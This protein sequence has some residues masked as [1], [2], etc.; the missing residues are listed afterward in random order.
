M[1]QIIG[2][3]SKV[4]GAVRILVVWVTLLALFAA[5]GGV[6]LT[7]QPAEA[8][9]FSGASEFKL[10]AS[11]GAAGDFFG[12]SADD[13]FGQPLAISGETA[14][15]GAWADDVGAGVPQ[16]SAYVFVKAGTTWSQQ[17]KLIAS[18]AEGYERFGWA[19]AIDGDTAVVGCMADYVGNNPEQGS[20][21]VFTRSGTTWSQQAQL[22]ASDG[23]EKDLFGWSVAIHGD[24]A[25]I[26]AS[27]DDVGGEWEVGSAYVFTRTG[28]T[29]NQQ[30]KLTATDGVAG[31]YFGESVAIDV[32]TV[33][34]GAVNGHVGVAGP[35]SA[36]VFTR[37]GTTWNQQ[38]KLIAPDGVSWDNFGE[39]VAI[40]GDTVVVGAVFDHIGAT[41]DQGSAYVFTRSGTSWSQQ[42][43]LT[44]SDGAAGDYFGIS[45]GISEDIAVIGNPNHDVESVSNQGSTYVFARSGTTWSEQAK[46]S[47]SDGA[48]EDKF[49][50]TVAISGDNVVV[51]APYD[52]V[53]ANVDQ[54]SA[55]IYKATSSTPTPTPSPTGEGEA[56]VSATVTLQ[57]ISV[58]IASGY[59]TSMDYGVMAPGTEAIPASYTP[60]TYSYLRVENQG[61][62]AEDF[63]I[64]GADASC[65]A[66]T[67]TLAATPGVNLYSHLYGTGQSPV[68]Y[69]PLSTAA[70]ILGS[71]VAV[72]GTVDFKLKIQ[73][74]TSSTV[75]GQYSTTVSILAVAH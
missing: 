11:D 25:V 6:A 2:R 27:S 56:H 24:T 47:A 32:D 37:T 70:S 53:G 63:L 48:A 28:T 21:Y 17:A 34:V 40:D 72:G 13:F 43:Q 71:N 59:P 29:W 14:I 74:P 10:T 51:G 61:S 33:V 35:G 60:G 42:A 4:Q 69:S 55:Y 23:A 22:I 68:G 1:R 39:S 49:A 9:D 16:G 31:D 5:L 19:V 50:F 38:A 54:G 8:A 26:G 41:V 20:A 12:G 66:G 30:A 45:V 7:P 73:T 64:K 65:G 62:V 18:D 58:T 67:W 44:A 36:Y 75:Y 52:D 3:S 46:L 15:V 57:S